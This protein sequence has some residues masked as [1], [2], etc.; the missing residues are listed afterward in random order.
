M[1][2]KCCQRGAALSQNYPTLAPLPPVLDALLFDPEFSS[3]AVIYNNI[4]ALSAVGIQNEE[5]GGWDT[6]YGDHAMRLSGRT[7]HKFFNSASSGGLQYFMHAA[8]DAMLQHGHDW[9]L[10]EAALR[11]IYQW[12]I[13]NNPLCQELQQIGMFSEILDFTLIGPQ[14]VAATINEITHELDISAIV[15]DHLDGQH[16]LQVHRK[17]ETQSTT[18]GNTDPLF[19]ALSYPLFFPFGEE[20]W[21]LRLKVPFQKYLISRMLM[22]ERGMVYPSGD[23]EHFFPTNRFQ[24]LHRLGQIYHIDQISR[25]IDRRLSQE[26]VHLNTMMRGVNQIRQR[27]VEAA[28]ARARTPAAPD[29]G[30]TQRRL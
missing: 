28:N 3:K 10:D 29:D 27:N 4:L 1:R 15:S 14:Q 9:L 16:V 26:R 20:G 25:I 11:N 21:C 23:G 13:Q 2:Q 30:E 12:L 17:N 18:V 5:G 7:Y 19:E 6:I 8:E 24:L 22:P